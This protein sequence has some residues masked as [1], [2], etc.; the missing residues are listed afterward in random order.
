MIGKFLT[1]TK[2]K[3]NVKE[4]V[5]VKK[6]KSDVLEDNDLKK[7]KVNHFEKFKEQQKVQNTV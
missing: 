3:T 1:T 6:N 4:K 5:K 2:Q 7:I